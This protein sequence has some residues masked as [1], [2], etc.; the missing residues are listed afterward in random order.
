MT[1]DT[2]NQQAWLNP[3]RWQARRGSL[4]TETLLIPFID[5][6]ALTTHKPPF[7]ATLNQ[8]LKQNDDDLGRWLLHPQQAPTPYQPLI[9]AIR[10]NYLNSKA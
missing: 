10:K 1:S 6:L 2:T 3:L 4:E 8:L 9:E 5:S 7:L